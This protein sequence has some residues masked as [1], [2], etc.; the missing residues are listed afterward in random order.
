M[1]EEPQATQPAEPELPPYIIEGARSG[2]S[3]CK[4]CRKKIAMGSLRIGILVVGPYGPGHM[5]HHLEC[6]AKRHFPKV[7]EAYEVAAWEFAKEP[8]KIVPSLEKLTQLREKAEKLKAER[9]EIP[10]AEISPSGRARCK[11]CEEL[12][13]KG[14]PRVVLGREVQFG[15]DLRTSRINVHPGCVSEALDAPESATEYA[16]FEFLLRKNSRGMEESQLDR[17]LGE[18]GSLD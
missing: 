9:K 10:F 8:P 16:G 15:L 13:D 6:A 2:R 18:I 1:S 7:E 5:W 11:H 3:S 12:I 4:T 17:I 14:A